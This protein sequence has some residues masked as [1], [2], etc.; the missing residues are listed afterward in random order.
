MP[1]RVLL[2]RGREVTGGEGVGEDPA[3]GRSTRENHIGG[4]EGEVRQEEIVV[5]GGEGVD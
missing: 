1:A 5:R 2:G 3:D 4:E